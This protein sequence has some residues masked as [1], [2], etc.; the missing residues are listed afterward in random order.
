MADR[1]YRAQVTIP[2]DSALPEDAV[3]N[4]WHFDDDDDPLAGPEDTQAWILQA[5]TSF[6]QSIDSVLFP[7]QVGAAATVRMYDLRDPQPRQP[8]ATETIALTP[9]AG[10]V[11]L[12]EAAVCLSYSATVA[13]GENPRRRRG[14]IFLGPVSMNASIVENGQRRPIAAARTAIATAAAAL[15][16]GIEHPGSPGLHLK[17]AVYSPTTDLVSTIDDAFHDVATGWIDNAFDIQ[18]RR[19]VSPTARTTF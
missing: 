5:L 4:T 9:T 19:G 7:L 18:R 17:W 14:R 8:R 6:Y 3:V 13:S 15:R 12:E 10:D 1:L 16:N 2:M 11:L